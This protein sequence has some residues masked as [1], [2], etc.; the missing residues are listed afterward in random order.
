MSQRSRAL[1]CVLA[2]ALLVLCNLLV[3]V[4]TVSARSPYILKYYTGTGTTRSFNDYYK[5]PT[6]F[7]VWGVEYTNANEYILAGVQLTYQTP[8]QVPWKAVIEANQSADLKHTYTTNLPQTLGTMRTAMVN[9]DGP[10]F[11]KVSANFTLTISPQ[12]TETTTLFINAE[13]LASPTEASSLA[14]SSCWPRSWR[15]SRTSR[16]AIRARQAL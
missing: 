14:T 11:M 7:S 16:P 4:P 8:G 13:T 1:F 6:D 3:I 10:N 5:T 12:T 9:F 15:T 2:V